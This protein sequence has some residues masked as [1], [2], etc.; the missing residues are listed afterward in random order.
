MLNTTKMSGKMKRII[1]MLLICAAALTVLSSCES[2]GIPTDTT[3]ATNTSEETVSP[4]LPAVSESA[5]PTTEE[6]EEFSGRS[7]VIEKPFDKEENLEVI[8]SEF[9]EKYKELFEKGLDFQLEFRLYG[10]DL[11]RNYRIGAFRFVNLWY[12]EKGYI[13]L[14]FMP[15]SVN[16]YGIKRIKRFS[17]ELFKEALEIPNVTKVEIV[18]EELKW[19]PKNSNYTIQKPIDE[20]ED[21]EGVFEEFC[22]K[23]KYFFDQWFKYELEFRVYGKALTSEEVGNLNFLVYWDGQ[24][25]CT[26]IRFIN[27]DATI[28]SQFNQNVDEFT[29][30][31]FKELVDMEEV[32]KIEMKFYKPFAYGC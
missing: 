7:Y 4:T 27:R 22:E 29:F 28:S 17:Y 12:L 3:T 21:I 5:E 31:M 20:K 6:T 25:D 8:F 32:T 19:T 1:S 24:D 23:Y 11:D 18:L 10:N 16:E 13:N 30:E 14:R 2:S 9:C 15:S 26:R